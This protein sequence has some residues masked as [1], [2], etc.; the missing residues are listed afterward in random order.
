MVR[1]GA[2]T[3]PNG[4]IIPED[5]PRV[6]S[7]WTFRLDSSGR[8]SSLRNLSCVLVAALVVPTPTFTFALADL[9]LTVIV[10]VFLALAW[11]RPVVRV[12][13][14]VGGGRVAGIVLSRLLPVLGRGRPWGFIARDGGLVNGVHITSILRTE[15][16]YGRGRHDE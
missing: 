16:W 15:P 9:F 12:V 8:R 14:F 10:A 13:T 11:F 5:L 1:D 3:F 7:P 2:S 4:A 6:P